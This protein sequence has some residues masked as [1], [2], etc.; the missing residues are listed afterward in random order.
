M[1]SIL[2]LTPVR[3]KK[4]GVTER[5]KQE[6]DELSQKVLNA[7]SSVEQLEAIVSSLTTKSNKLQADLAT[8]ETNKANALSNK[9]LADEV[10][11][12]LLALKNN[13]EV[14]FNETVLAE[15][16]IKTVSKEVS[17][18]IDKL[19]FSAEI[20]NKL[21][22][23]VVRKKATNPL[24]SDELVTMVTTASADANNAVALT[25]VALQSVFA[26]QATTKESEAAVALEML[27]AV[28]LYEF[29]IGEET[30]DNIESDATLSPATSIQGL[31]HKAYDINENMYNQAL[32]ASNDTIKQLNNTKREL[33]KAQTNLSSLQSALAAANAAALAS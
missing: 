6:L 29:V 10:V 12:N 2:S 25:L 33:S 31:L 32:A 8:A 20:I 1:S 9:D 7:E 21:G 18:L 19:I 5:K 22:N 11:E 3:Q 23:L 17:N 15:S 24:I 30:V 28:K 13:S 26:A 4:Y 27:Q 16:K 14:T